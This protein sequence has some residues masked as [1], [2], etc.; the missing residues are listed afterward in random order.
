MPSGAS[1]A[2]PIVQSGGVTH[3]FLQGPWPRALAHRGWHID[4]LNG[5]E[6]SLSAFRRAYAEGYLYVETDV[7][8]TSDGVVVVHHDAS[9]DRTTDHRGEIR[10]LRWSAARSAMIG[11]REPVCRLDDVLEELPDV[12]LNID[13]KADSAVQ[14]VLRTLR[15]HNA[16]DRVCLAA[17]DDR[18]LGLL[19]N[20]GDRR[21]LTSMGQQA[22]QALWGASR[23]G[24]R[25]PRMARGFAA[26]V[27]PTQGRIRVVD[28]RFV[29]LARLWG[30][31]VHAWTVDD[32]EEM[33]DL[34]DLGV[35]GLVTDRPDV[36]REVLRQR[37]QW[38]G[39]S[40]PASGT[41]MC[42]RPEIP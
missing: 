14:P 42:E 36:L 20:G 29:R 9:L 26:Q 11:G 31:E 30:V 27:P 7:H 21:L 25:V 10:E 37:D 13:V 16:W 5:M 41:R 28:N 33:T 2:T 12:F 15:Q 18:R 34:L 40:E 39:A 17:F 35:D 32:A 22:A 6:N 4:E 19:R 24:L 38:P 1:G 3:P 23:L 8:A